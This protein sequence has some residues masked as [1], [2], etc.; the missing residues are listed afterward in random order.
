[1]CSEE[2]QLEMSHEL[3]EWLIA[4]IHHQESIQCMHICTF[5]STFFVFA[6]HIAGVFLNVSK[7]TVLFGHKSEILNRIECEEHEV[8]F[9]F[10]LFNASF[11][12]LADSFY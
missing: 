1:L 9:N 2:K 3:I 12:H 8:L 10:S 11:M 6:Q 5:A 7:I 4:H